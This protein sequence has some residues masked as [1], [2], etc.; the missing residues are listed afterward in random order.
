[1][2]WLS[3][4]CTVSGSEEKSPTQPQEKTV[5]FRLEKQQGEDVNTVKN[6]TYQTTIES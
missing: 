6:K 2:P 3:F 5:G 4:N 1:M